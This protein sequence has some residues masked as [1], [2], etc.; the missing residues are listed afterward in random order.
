MSKINFVKLRKRAG[1]SQRELADLLQVRPS[2]VSA[3]ENGKSRMPEEKLDKIKEIFELDSLD[4]YMIDEHTE[5]TVPPHTHAMDQNDTLAQLLNHFHD[6]AHQREREHS[7]QDADTAAR[8]EFLTKRNDRLSERVDDLRD[9]VD[10]L[11]EENLR[12]KELL[13][14]NGIQY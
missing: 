10:A 8:I 9:E 3:I 7:G 1:M 13:I 11:S 2:F 5:Q 14:K 12:L 6:L 4:D